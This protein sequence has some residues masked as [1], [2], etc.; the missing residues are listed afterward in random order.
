MNG[1]CLS[2]IVGRQ[3]RQVEKKSSRLAVPLLGGA[4]TAL[5]GQERLGKVGTTKELPVSR[6]VVATGKRRV[7]ACGG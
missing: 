5:Q 3:N 6:G 1:S 2:A 7:G 4:E